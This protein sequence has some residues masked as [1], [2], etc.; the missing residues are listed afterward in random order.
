MD[1]K[2]AK[3]I[4]EKEAKFEKTKK[5][6]KNIKHEKGFRLIVKDIETGDIIINEAINALVGGWAKKTSVGAVG[7]AM[8]VM[9]CNAPTIVSAVASAE[10]AVEQAKLSTVEGV[11]KNHDVLEELLSKIILGGKK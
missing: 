2:K 7:A 3:W 10:E 1:N 8:V 11:L 6:F 5:E 9:A 4:E